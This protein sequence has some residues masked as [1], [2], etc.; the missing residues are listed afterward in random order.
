MAEARLFGDLDEMK[1]LVAERGGEA[2]LP[3]RAPSPC[4]LPADVTA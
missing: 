1:K 3:K 4:V 2:Y